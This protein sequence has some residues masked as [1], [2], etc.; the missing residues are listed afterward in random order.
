MGSRN[1][2]LNS[3]DYEKAAARILAPP[4]YDYYRGGAEDEVT[5]D[6]NV[7]AFRRIQFRP[8]VLR[9]VSRVSTH[10]TIHGH[11]LSAPFIIAPMAMQK[12]AHEHGEIATAAASRTCNIG[13]ALSTLATS[14]I[15]EVAKHTGE[16]RLFQ[17][18]VYRE[19]EVTKRLI[20]RAEKAGYQGL[21][22]TV[23]TPCLGRREKDVRNRFRM[24]PH[25]V[26]ENFLDANDEKVKLP[27]EKAEEEGNSALAL[28]GAR[29]LDPDLTWEDVKWLV[30]ESSMHVWLKGITRGDEAMKA[31]ETGVHGII[32]SNHGGRQLDGAGA[33]VDALEEVVR[34]LS[35]RLP[36]ILDSG[37]RRGADVVRALA[38]GATAVMIG[39]PV[40]W[41]LAVGGREGVTHL[42][43]ILKQEM[44]L[45]MA[46]CGASDFEEI[47]RDMVQTRGDR[48]GL[49]AKL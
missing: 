30:R 26:L 20:K 41:A 6:A 16:F 23:D 8:R 24:P 4:I 2:L 27:G 43:D 15:E 14:S 34:A 3:S 49:M 22:I 11:R 7:Q 36:V 47:D 39:R 29:L 13:Y 48:C 18:Y 45:T 44:S 21:V 1:D 42:I 46:L 32:V 17:L 25:L 9:P 10:V 40:L 33:T 35:G 38:L 19:R 28:Y 31:Y 5:L 37:V 12:M